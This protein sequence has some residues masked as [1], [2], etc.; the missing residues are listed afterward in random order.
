MDTIKLQ[1]LRGYNRFS[2][3]M[4]LLFLSYML[5][6]ISTCKFILLVECQMVVFEWQNKFLT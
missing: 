4:C 6:N 1:L 2:F 3:L 5:Y